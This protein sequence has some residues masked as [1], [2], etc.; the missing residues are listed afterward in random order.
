MT[1]VQTCAL[2]ISDFVPESLKPYEDAL[3]MIK[4]GEP[5]S[6]EGHLYNVELRWPDAAKEAADPLSEEHFLD[7]YKPMMEQAPAIK[8]AWQATKQHLPENALEDLGGDLS[9]LYGRDVTPED[10]LGTMSSIGGNPGFGE[11]LLRKIGR[12]HV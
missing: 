2:P 10:F 9:L 5:I 1:G 4:S 12:A 6:S 11:Q 8:K 7:W 3:Q